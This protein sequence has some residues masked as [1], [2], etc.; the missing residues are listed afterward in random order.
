MAGNDQANQQATCK[1]EIGVLKLAQ[2]G[3]F[4]FD[5]G[6][7]PDWWASALLASLKQGLIRR[8]ESDKQGPLWVCVNTAS[9]IRYA[10][11]I[12]PAVGER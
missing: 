12:T 4:L 5:S 2:T 10:R 1:Q 11:S 8:L 3:N 9:E 7:E 6:E